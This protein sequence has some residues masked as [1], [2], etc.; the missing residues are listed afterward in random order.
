MLKCLNNDS[1]IQMRLNI[2]RHRQKLLQCLENT[3]DTF[4]KPK[5]KLISNDLEKF[6]LNHN[7]KRKTRSSIPV[8]QLQPNVRVNKQYEPLSNVELK[9]EPSPNI[10][11]KKSE[12]PSVTLK[13][14][15]EQLIE[16]QCYS[17]SSDEIELCYSSSSEEN[18]DNISVGNNE[19]WNEHFQTHNEN[20][21]DNS[22]II[23]VKY[24][25]Q[26]QPANYKSKEKYMDMD[27]DMDSS[28]DDDNPV[29]DINYSPSRKRSIVIPKKHQIKV[30]P[31]KPRL[32]K[33]KD[34][35]IHNAKERACRSRL[36]QRF[37]Y[38]SN[39]CSYVNSNRRVPSKVSIL[40]A[41]KKECGLLLHFNNKIIAEKKW[42]L[43]VHTSSE[44]PEEKK[45]SQ[46]NTNRATESNPLS[47][48]VAS[49][50][51]AIGT[52]TLSDAQ[53]KLGMEAGVGAHVDIKRTS[54]DVSVDPQCTRGTLVKKQISPKSNPKYIACLLKGRSPNLLIIYT[55]KK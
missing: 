41:A 35:A 39:Y 4:L 15:K 13:K 6:N 27:K 14:L 48:T 24:N 29:L 31:S 51:E 2:K 16:E 34:K 55:I 7:V 26:E 9:L 19:D 25:G 17:S 38:L 21:S 20:D 45:Q 50:V 11:I 28:S 42:L 12:P 5:I 30:K 46:P 33:C 3:N 53:D 23:E 32:R 54:A 22:S 49:L 10:K 8:N 40:L 43:Q 44:L 1:K 18:D 37:Q 52:G 36:A 47:D